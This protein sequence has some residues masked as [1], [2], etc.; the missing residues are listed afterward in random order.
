MAQNRNDALH[1]PH[2]PDEGCRASISGDGLEYLLSEF[3]T[4]DESH[5]HGQCCGDAKENRLEGPGSHADGNT[6]CCILDILFQMI[7]AR[8][9]TPISK[10]PVKRPIVD[11]AKNQ[12]NI[13]RYNRFDRCQDW[14]VERDG[15][16]KLQRDAHRP[17]C[18]ACPEPTPLS[19]RPPPPRQ[20]RDD[21]NQGHAHAGRQVSY[22]LRR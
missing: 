3:A 20:H 4:E 10:T 22:P 16:G 17:H 14:R 18:R 13:V 2:Q 15:P 6:S 9:V 12:I 21:A 8:S 1:G 11:G 5:D 7:A 19:T